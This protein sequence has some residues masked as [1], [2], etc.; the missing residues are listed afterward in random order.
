[1]QWVKNN[2]TAVAWMVAA[3]LLG[4]MIGGSAAVDML[5]GAAVGLAFSA[6]LS[7][8]LY[9]GPSG[10]AALNRLI[11][12]L[13]VGGVAAGLW[14]AGYVFPAFILQGLYAGSMSLIVAAAIAR[15]TKG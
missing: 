5:G 10:M 12:A 7:L 3:T 9:A 4:G 6:Y 13:L 14:Y 8:Y 2:S 1:M 15:I 11:P